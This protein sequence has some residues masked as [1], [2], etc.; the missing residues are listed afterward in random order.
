MSLINKKHCKLLALYVSKEHRNNKFTRV[1]KE[2]LVQL[3]Y[4]VADMITNAV[5]QHPSKG[6][7][8]MEFR[9]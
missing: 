4:N 6:K 7:T 3:E 9:K 8:L 1:S 2:F 5:K